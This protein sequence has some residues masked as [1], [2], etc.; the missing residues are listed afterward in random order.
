MWSLITEFTAM[1]Y[2]M[3]GAGL[4]MVL[5]AKLHAS[6]GTAGHR[7]LGGPMPVPV[8]N[9]TSGDAGEGGHDDEHEHNTFAHAINVLKWSL[10][11]SYLALE[12]GTMLHKGVGRNC[13]D[14]WAHRDTKNGRYRIT[15]LVLKCVT[16]LAISV[17]DYVFVEEGSALV[18][19]LCITIFQ[20]LLKRLER[21][22]RAN[23]KAVR[24]ENVLERNH[25]ETKMIASLRGSHSELVSLTDIEDGDKESATPYSKLDGAM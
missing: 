3:V 6:K 5:E 2:I 23:K 8:N 19:L 11:G 22:L 21:F 4:K 14:L 13:R 17:D 10:I 18:F 15:V 25:S 24:R 12:Y 7:R 9:Q 1:T 20:V 16:A